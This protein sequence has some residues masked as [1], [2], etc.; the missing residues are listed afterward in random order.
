M[1]ITRHSNS[2]DLGFTLIELLVVI[3]IV[4]LL[5][6]ILLPVIGQARNSARDL[7]CLSN[8]RQ[9]G[10]A[11]WT[12]ATDNNDKPAYSRQANLAVNGRS[13]DWFISLRDYSAAEGV[14]KLLACPRVENQNGGTVPQRFHGDHGTNYWIGKDQYRDYSIETSGNGISG[15]YGYNNWWEYDATINPGPWNQVSLQLGPFPSVYSPDKPSLTP[16]IFDSTY[17]DLGWPLDTSVVSASW[18]NTSGTRSNYRNFDRI[19]IARHGLFGS[20]DIERA[21]ANMVMADGSAGFTPASKYS[22][23]TWSRTFVPK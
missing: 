3:S 7:Q 1:S 15:G 23:L 10:I 19:T 12:Q 6:A 9:W 4:A 18:M 11:W 14:N 16:V 20:T 2:R 13:T 17:Y 5:L 22:S 21:G 8:T